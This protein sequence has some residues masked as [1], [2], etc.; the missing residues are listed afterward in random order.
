MKKI[1]ILIVFCIICADPP[2][3]EDSPWQYEY[4]AHLVGVIFHE[5]EQMADGGDLFAAFDEEGNVRGLGNALFVSFG[6]YENSTLWEFTLRSNEQVGDVLS[7]QYYDASQ[8]A[9][10]DIV[11]TYSFIADEIL[12]SIVNPLEFTAVF[13]EYEVGCT[14]PTASN[15]NPQ[16]NIDDG[17]CEYD[18]WGCT[19]PSALNYNP[20]ATIDDDSCDY[21]SD[22]FG[23]MY[24]NATNYNPDA[25]V[26]DGS[27]EFL[28]CD[29]NHDGAVNVI[30][31]VS[32]VTVIIGSIW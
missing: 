1:L 26:D 12:G 14:D 6:P 19:D 29:I 24:S 16:A 9:I 17:T 31:V 21:E 27:C 13:L 15:Y 18:V 22:V 10:L 7:F 20:D 3:W 2:D 28:W 8:D 32:L 5:D 25:N 23:C 30:D 4:T 11:E